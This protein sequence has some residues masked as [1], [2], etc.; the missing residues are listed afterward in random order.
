[1]SPGSLTSSPT[2]DDFRAL[3]RSSPW[4]FT[5]LHFTH[6][7]RDG[8]RARQAPV[9]A[10]LDRNVRTVTVRSARGIT[11]IATGVPYSSATIS[12][13]DV[14]G[15]EDLG[16]APQRHEPV[17]RPDG[18][19]GKRPYD[20]HVNHGDPMVR[21]YRWTAMLDPAELSDGVDVS[22]VAAITVRGRATWTATCRPLIGEGED[23]IGGYAP[24]CGCCPLLDSKASRLPEFG[25]DHPDLVPEDLPTAYVVQLDVQTGIVVD[26]TP[27]DGAD[28]SSLANE[29]HAVDRPLEAPV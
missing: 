17:I 9:E 16:F 20:W 11:E 14:H 15:A 5:T 26:I 4:R 8:N 12:A 3:A 25:E 1:M 13:T 23:W 29:I 24:R 22:E 2:A 7:S 10:W 21:N 18:L 27:L 6:S 19:V 28:G